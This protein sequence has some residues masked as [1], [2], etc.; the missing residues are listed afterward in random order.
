MAKMSPKKRVYV[1]FWKD[2]QG[3]TNYESFLP[4]D[5]VGSVVKTPSRAQRYPET[6]DLSELISLAKAWNL[7]IRLREKGDCPCCSREMK[8]FIFS[9][10][11][12]I[13]KAEEEPEE[14]QACNTASLDPST[15]A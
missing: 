13:H 8:G 1:Q 6:F 11:D 10:I 9:S 7:D 12:D 14:A 2:E 4:C 5:D 15:G 3:D